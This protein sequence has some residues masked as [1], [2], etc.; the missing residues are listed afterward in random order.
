MPFGVQKVSGVH[1]AL[2]VLVIGSALWHLWRQAASSVWI[3]HHFIQSDT[4]YIRCCTIADEQHM[5][6]MHDNT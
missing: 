3:H 4:L 6:D 5:L 1:R 2:S